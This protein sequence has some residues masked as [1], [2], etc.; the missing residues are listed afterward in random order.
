MM[1]KK[2]FLLNIFFVFIYASNHDF[3]NMKRVVKNLA[4]IFEEEHK[5]ENL[6]L[7]VP[8]VSTPEKDYAELVDFSKID[9]SSQNDWNEFA[10][11]YMPNVFNRKFEAGLRKKE[12]PVQ[13]TNFKPEN[14]FLN[15]EDLAL[16]NIEDPAKK[17]VYEKVLKHYTRA[18]YCAYGDKSDVDEVR[19]LIGLLS[20]LELESIQDTAYRAAL[21]KKPLPKRLP[22]NRM[23]QK[24]AM[25]DLFEEYIDPKE[26]L[27][28]NTVEKIFDEVLLSGDKADEFFSIYKKL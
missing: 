8:N 6:I 26:K 20:I 11:V 1:I 9:L 4:A 13:S 2:L 5:G 23:I 18:V 22:G 19:K 17:E 16:K 12:K 25:M 14:I 24:V 27:M 3:K 28:T 15:Y 7:K 10:Q 21:E